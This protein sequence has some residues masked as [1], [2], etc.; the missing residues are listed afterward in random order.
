[1]PLTNDYNIGD[2]VLA[3]HKGAWTIGVIAE[4]RTVRNKT[5]LTLQVNNFIFYA[6]SPVGYIAR[7]GKK[8]AEYGLLIGHRFDD[9]EQA[10]AKLRS[11]GV[12]I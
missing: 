3:P 5:R 12:S 6:E 11:M 7:R 4:I 10:S 2:L 9:P 8:R 1:M